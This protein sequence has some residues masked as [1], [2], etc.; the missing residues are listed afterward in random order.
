[1]NAMSVVVEWKAPFK[2][3]KGY[4]LKPIWNNSGPTPHI[5]Y[6]ESGCKAAIS[7]KCEQAYIVNGG[8]HSPV[9][10]FNPNIAWTPQIAAERFGGGAGSTATGA[11]QSRNA[12]TEDNDCIVVEATKNAGIRTALPPT[13]QGVENEGPEN[14]QRASDEGMNAQTNANKGYSQPYN[15]ELIVQGDPE[16]DSPFQWWHKYISI[17]V[18]NPFHPVLKLTGGS[19]QIKDADW[20]ASPICNPILTSKS[21]RIEKVSHDIKEGSYTT[22]ISVARDPDTDEARSAAKASRQAAA[23]S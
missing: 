15:A 8:K 10:S 3:D 20:L 1:M 12:S 13:E 5:M 18:V 23:G 6:V 4:G 9:I 16:M 17:V 11:S 19:G 7:D 14:A 22:T 21:Y 2:T